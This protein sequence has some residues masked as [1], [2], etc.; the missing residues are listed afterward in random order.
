MK[1]VAKRL[2]FVKGPDL[3]FVNLKEGLIVDLPERYATHPDLIKYIEPD[4][5]NSELTKKITDDDQESD[6]D[7]KKLDKK[8]LDDFAEQMGIK[9]N[10]RNTLDKMQ[11]D[12]EEKLKGLD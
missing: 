6:F 2:A 12:F 4:Q 9:L 11:K 5:S 8:G 7:W 1:F 3:E 10:R